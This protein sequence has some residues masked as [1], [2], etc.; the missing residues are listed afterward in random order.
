MTFAQPEWLVALILVP[1]LALGSWLAWHKRGLRWRRLVAPRLQSRLSHPR[2]GWIH[3]VALGAALAGWSGLV[4]AMAQPESGEEWVEVQNEGRNLLFCIDISRS[5]LCQDV[6]PSRLGASRAAALEILEKYPNDR[7]GVVLF[8]GEVLVQSPLTLDHGYV[9]ETLAQLDPDDIPYGGSNLGAA[10]EA[11]T[12]LLQATGQQN[13]LMVV[14][15]DGEKSTEGLAA[16]AMKARDAG[17][18][19]Y[20]LG[21]GTSEG[22]FIPDDRE[23]DGRFR[24]RDGN[25]VHTRLDEQ[26]LELL[27]SETGGYYSRGMGSGF[28][29]RL[30]T[31]LAEMDRFREDGK[32]RRVAK[33]A[34]QW[35]AFGGVILLMSSLIIRSLPLRPTLAALAFVLAWP[36]V[37]AGEIENGLAALEAGQPAEAHLHFRNAARDAGPFRAPRLHLSAGSAAAQ[38]DDWEAAISSF[39]EALASEDRAI[40]HQAHYGLGASLFYHGARL[41][42]EPRVKAWQ[43]ALSHFEAAL[44]ISPDDQRSRDNLARIQE[45]LRKPDPETPP[46]NQEEDQEKKEEK[47]E[48][49]EKENN[50]DPQENEAGGQKQ[51]NE[52]DPDEN[53][54]PGSEKTDDENKTPGE[55]PNSND[56]PPR[57]DQPGETPGETPEGQQV[58]PGGEGRDDDRERKDQGKLADD[59][60]APKDESPEAR[61]RRLIRQYSDLGDKAPR[62]TR[63]PFNR[64]EHDW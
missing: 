44:Q 55:E 52:Q 6:A 20:A 51:N 24:D 11:G 9:E 7:A 37:E 46:P 26:S 38:A 23:R 62:R 60:D 4:I 30:T 17:V 27:A 64:R 14:L 41:E 28:L 21:M 29:A 42:E 8:A 13:N 40:Q 31:A 48:K 50:D 54:Q 1:F 15:S 53:R 34:H 58:N 16:A 36:E 39:S 5:M 3:F 18:F 32:F 33:P 2:P 25:V 59:P 10:I 35:F 45:Y 63:R 43:D 57:E 22:S 12:T 47:E 49:S 19:V 61:A 56:G